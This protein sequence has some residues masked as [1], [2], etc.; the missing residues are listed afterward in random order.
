MKCNSVFVYASHV[1]KEKNK[2]IKN[3]TEFTFLKMT[4]YV[5]Y[6]DIPSKEDCE[7]LQEDINILGDWDDQ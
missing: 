6:R 2:L 4:V 3:R 1:S 7:K 5:F